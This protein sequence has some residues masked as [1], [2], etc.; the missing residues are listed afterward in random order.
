MTPTQSILDRFS[1][2][3]V[4][5]LA[6]AIVIAVMAA[7]CGG[8]APS[9]PTAS[10]AGGA[11]A[12]GQTAYRFAAC[13]RAHG[14]ANFPDPVVKTSGGSVQ[15]A[16]A[17]NPSISGQPAFKSAQASCS[18]ILPKGG[19]GPDDTPAQRQAR[20][21]AFLAFAR[22]LRTHGFPT[23]P[24]PDATGQLSQEM[25]RQAGINFHTPALLTAGQR[26]A[27]VTHGL[28]TP[29]QVAQAVNHANASDGQTST[30]P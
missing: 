10:A 19:N 14:L 16:I 26:C 8:S 5:A 1:H 27:A 9:P 24:D 15:V 3:Q 4:L 7:G 20:T 18:H 30:S 21:Q 6:G 23:F 22:C 17:I 28:I 2:P 13:M 25:I 11:G 12:P 29:A